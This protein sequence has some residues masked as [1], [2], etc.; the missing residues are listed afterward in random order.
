MIRSTFVFFVAFI[1]TLTT[2]SAGSVKGD[3][4]S[5]LQLSEGKKISTNAF[6]SATGAYTINAWGFTTTDSGAGWSITGGHARYNLGNSIFVAPVY[7]PSG[8]LITD[9]YVDGC[10]NSSDRQI[11][12][13]LY[14]CPDG[15][16][17]TAVA[18]ASTG[19]PETPGCGM[20]WLPTD[21]L[22]DQATHTYLV[23][24]VVSATMETTQFRSVRLLY[25]REVSPGPLT[26]TFA[27]VPT[28]HPFFRFVEALAAA[29]VTGGC[30]GGNYCPNNP[31][32]RGQMA[33]FLA[34]ALGL[35]WAP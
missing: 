19:L 35:H 29:G 2:A 30:G 15:S 5:R 17:C 18:Q 28:D 14:E 6:G 32:T 3:E 22:L 4:I 33:V 24:L 9:V 34:A 16:A 12:V 7:L 27:D 13:W 26:A 10:D 11:A 21:L 31:I 23:Q 20:F 25:H 1:F 8:V